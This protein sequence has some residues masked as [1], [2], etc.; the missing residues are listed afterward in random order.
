MSTKDARKS[1]EQRQTMDVLGQGVYSIVE[2]AKLTGLR[3][4]RVREW[5]RGRVSDPIP[6]P[7]FRSDFEAVTGNSISFLDL[8][9][10]FIAGQLRGHGVSLQYIRRAHA[11]LQEDW[12]TRHP[13]SRRDIRTH[14]QELFVCAL[15]LNDAERAIVYEVITKNQVFENIILPTLQKIDYDQATDLASKWHLT[16]MVSLNPRVCFGKPVVDAIGIT[17][18]VLAASYFANGQNAKAVASWY[19]IEEQHVMAAVEYEARNAA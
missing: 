11:R 10:V 13:F 3:Q 2:A 12:K 6:R 8:V 15:D 14:G 1:G 9:E 4:A 19:E 18:H 17:T 5:F 7:V 16:P